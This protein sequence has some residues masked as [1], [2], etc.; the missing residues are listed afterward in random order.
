MKLFILNFLNLYPRDRSLF[1]ETISFPYLAEEDRSK[2]K[3]LN[4]LAFNHILSTPLS[5]EDEYLLP[6][7]GTISIRAMSFAE[8]RSSSALFL[9]GLPF[10]NINEQDLPNILIPLSSRL[11]PGRKSRTSDIAFPSAILL[12]MLD[13]TILF[14]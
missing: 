6:A 3:V 4:A 7:K 13:T 5:A 8:I 14:E 11:N 1:S 2:R 9:S 12:S 10:K